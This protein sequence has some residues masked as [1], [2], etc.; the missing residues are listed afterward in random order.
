V[1]FNAVMCPCHLLILVLNKSFAFLLNFP[2]YLF[3]KLCRALGERAR[4]QSD[5]GG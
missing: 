1:G 3:Q 5:A 4:S 2:T